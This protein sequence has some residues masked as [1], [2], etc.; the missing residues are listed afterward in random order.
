MPLHF[1]N[2][3]D[4]GK[5][6]LDELA[7]ELGSP[8]DFRKAGRILKC[9]LHKLRDR[10]ELENSIWFLNQLPVYLKAVFVDGW[11]IKNGE[12]DKIY[13]LENFI[14]GLMQE[15]HESAVKDFYSEELTISRIKDVFRVL[16]R[17]VKEEER[18][19]MEAMLPDPLH[20]L[21]KDSLVY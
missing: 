6:F 14:A 3:V 5:A 10:M 12:P 2:H 13:S 11:S 16:S 18:L 19:E 4:K 8:G 9:V 21:W 20:E 17:H 1:E 15:D 7:N